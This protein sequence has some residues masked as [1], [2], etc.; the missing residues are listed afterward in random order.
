MTANRL[1]RLKVVLDRVPVSKST[2]YDWME[3]GKF[4]AAVQLGGGIVAWRESEIDSWIA[5]R[6]LNLTTDSPGVGEGVA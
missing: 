4:P 5:E 6:P 1:I 3:R 2:I